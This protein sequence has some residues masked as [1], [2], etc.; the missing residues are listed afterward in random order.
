MEFGCLKKYW[1]DQG[2]VL[3]AMVTS[4]EQVRITLSS[5]RNVMLVLSL[6][7]ED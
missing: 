2:E 7:G 5:N 1:K 3:N 6:S 4:T